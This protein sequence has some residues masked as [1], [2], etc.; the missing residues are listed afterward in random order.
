MSIFTHTQVPLPAD[1]KFKISP[2]SISKFFEYPSVW[3]RENVLGERAFNGSTATHL[4]TS[5][6][7]IAEQFALS[8]INGTELD[9]DT[10]A[11]TIEDDLDLVDNPDVNHSEVL[12]LY[13]DM[14]SALI[15]DYLRYNIPTEVETPLT[16]EIQD[17]I[18]VGGTCDNFTSG[19]VVDYKS[20]SKKPN[21]DK[22]PWNYYI[23]L[24]AYA[25]MY[26]ERGEY[27]DRIRIVYVVRPTKTLPIRTF[28]V[29]QS[30]TDTD[31]QAIDDVLSLIAETMLLHYSKPEYTH[32]LFKSMSLKQT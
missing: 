17:G 8:H 9:A 23:Q 21:E 10:I 26:K 25:K 18:Y 5:M 13:Q 14:G 1:A 4:G 15:N 11:Q 24:M 12:S 2:S 3:F 16:L 20:S 32:L 6:H 22:I 7:Y 27:V 28:V 19:V 29:T 31:W 30:I